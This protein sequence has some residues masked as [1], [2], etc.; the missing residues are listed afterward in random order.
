VIALN[1]TDWAEKPGL[2]PGALQDL[3]D[4]GW[5]GLESLGLRAGRPKDGVA[6]D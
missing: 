6:R 4:S 2:G 1:W 3:V 5:A